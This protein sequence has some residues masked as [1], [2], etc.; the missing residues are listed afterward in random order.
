[1]HV[2]SSYHDRWKIDTRDSFRTLCRNADSIN[3]DHDPF[4]WLLKQAGHL[5]RR[6][7]DHIDLPKLI[8]H[9]TDEANRRAFLIRGCFRDIVH[10]LILLS[11]APEADAEVRTNWKREVS[12]QRI[13]FQSI[14]RKNPS[15]RRFLPAIY[16]FGW[17]AG[18]MQASMDLSSGNY[19]NPE[20]RQEVLQSESVLGDWSER[21]TTRCPWSPSQVVGFDPDDPHEALTDSYALPFDEPSR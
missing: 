6:E 16:N 5:N 4:A 19:L 7:F 21:L 20:I 10:H 3:N 11:T 18:R 8:D 12:F 1:M 9:L 17:A 2:L 13:K 14:L 15:L